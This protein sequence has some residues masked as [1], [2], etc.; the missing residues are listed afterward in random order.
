MINGKTV[1]LL[2]CRISKQLLIPRILIGYFK[3]YR[4][5]GRRNDHSKSMKATDITGG[6]LPVLE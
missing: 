3:R 1:L 6:I 4:R 2:G 5:W